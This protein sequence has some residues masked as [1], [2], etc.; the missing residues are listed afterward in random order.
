MKSMSLRALVAS[1]SL[2]AISGCYVD[3]DA[4]AAPQLDPVRPI[5]SL[6]DAAVSG[7]AE[8]FAHV[9][10][11]GGSA[12][13]SAEADGVTG[14]F[15]VAVPLKDGDNTLSVVAVDADSNKSEAA[16]VSVVREPP[17]AEVVRLTLE[18]NVIDA[19]DAALVAIID[20]DNDEDEI[21]L[22]LSVVDY[23]AAPAA[24]AVVLD[25]AGHARVVL[26]GLTLAAGG[27]V[28]A[29]ADVA[30]LDGVKAKD[31]AAFT[32]VP[33]AAAAVAVLLS[34]T[35]DGALVGPTDDLTIPAGTDVDVDVTVTDAHE[36]VVTGGAVRL[37][38]PGAGAA[39]AGNTLLHLERAGSYVV[40][41]DTGLGLLAGEATLNVEPGAVDHVVVSV[42]NAVVAAGTVVTA[43][44]AA[45]DAFD[46]LV[47]A[48]PPTLTTDAPQGFGAPV[49]V[50]GVA[51][52]TATITTAGSYTITADGGAG[53]SASVA[54]VVVAATPQNANF[55]EIDPAGLPY[56]AGDA[57][58]FTYDFVDAFGNVNDDVDVIVTVNAANVAVVDGG[59]G[60]G[61]IDGIVRAGTYT[62]RARALG[63]G[64]PDD[65]ETLTIDPNPIDAGFNLVL[66]AGLIAEQGTLLFFAQDGFGNLIDVADVTVSVSDPTAATQS[67]NQL[68]F[69]RP[70]TYAVTACLVDDAT[71]C[72]SEFISVQGLLDT[73]PPSVAVA[74]TFPDPA[75]SNEVPPR[76]L[77][78]FRVDSSDDRGLSEIRFVATFGTSTG[79]QSFCTVT[80]TGVLLPTGTTTDSRSF[81]FSLPACALPLDD[82]RVVA[83]AIDQA[84]NS[85]NSA[86]HTP[87]QVAANFNITS[88]NF[89]VEVAAFG[90][91]LDQPRDVAVDV[92]TGQLFVSD[93][94]SDRI[95]VVAPDRTQQDLRDR[96]G[97][98]LNPQ[99]PRGVA[100]D[101]GN[102]LFIV[103][104]DV[105][106]GD[107]GVERLSANFTDTS[108]L[109]D[110]NNISGAF[111][112]RGDGVDV[113]NTA[114]KTAL[115]CAGVDQA[116]RVQCFTNFT[117]APSLS[118]NQ[119]ITGRRPI[120]V[121]FDPPSATNPTDVLWVALNA[122]GVA[123]RPFTFN[124]ART[125]LTAGTDLNLS[126]V[127]QAGDVG[128][129]VVAASGNLIVSNQRTG[130]VFRVT[131]AGVINEIARGF[132][133]PRGLAF[134][135]NSLLVV[136][137]GDDAVFRVS[138]DPQAPGTF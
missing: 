17:R 82:I 78:T 59:D 6:T 73:V 8:P 36:N 81:S 71:V 87:L 27:R 75:Q 15:A 115:L 66:S 57:V 116:D 109:I 114:G 83:Q 16:T 89:I 50:D 137:E 25:A 104:D 19:D 136:A 11:S 24:V 121:A 129:V 97:N 54:V 61:E 79:T 46:N 107:P 26:D 47:A 103:A 118:I 37:D 127:F 117:A 124:A 39:V 52:A 62:V 95:I 134:D 132:Q 40:V 3:D 138:P 131:R 96:N 74:I 4:P 122:G 133:T 130:V 128:D 35:V 21:D 106:N 51:T 86:D 126:A 123:L 125:T 42:D 41:A 49:V 48:T 9:V 100:L 38:V 45:F 93:G 65:V 43:T 69:T 108:P 32:V 34:A 72:D 13:A 10:V 110:Q 7:V 120:A 20:V 31:E 12:E 18:D 70:G 44:A 102:N 29:E 30:D 98:R 68:T 77:V 53:A 111:P 22:T 56:A 92:S 99:T 84:G 5:T 63:T 119:L 85:A 2:C 14:R 91:R 135:G 105:G 33:G 90:D 1:V 60:T 58:F 94:G 23:A 64:L 88:P 67:G 28:V 113:D 76:G 55:F 101:A 112:N 80:R